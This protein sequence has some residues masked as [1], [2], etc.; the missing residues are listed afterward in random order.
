MIYKHFKIKIDSS[1]WPNGNVP[2]NL[3]KL[4][5][6]DYKI[7]ILEALYLIGKLTRPSVLK[8]FSLSDFWAWL[9]YFPAFDPHCSEAR[10]RK[11]WDSL[12]S[13]QKTIASD[14]L[15]MGFSCLF[16]KENLDINHFANT[17]HVLANLSKGL[18][19]PSPLIK[20]KGPKKTPDFIGFHF[21]N[22]LSI[23][24][25]KGTQNT[26]NALETSMMD[27]IEQKQNLQRKGA[28]FQHRLVAGTFI[29]QNSNSQNPTIKVIDPEWKIEGE[30][31]KYS[32]YDIEN[33]IIQ[34]SFAN[35]LSQIGF[36]N[37]SKIFSKTFEEEDI[38][39]SYEKDI[40]DID[41][42]G[43]KR[44]NEMWRKNIEVVWDEPMEYKGNSFGGIKY[45][46]EV[47]RTTIEEI[48]NSK[49]GSYFIKNFEEKFRSVKWN[50]KENIDNS[51]KFETESPLG[52]NYKLELI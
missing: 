45:S 9:R 38:D 23:I 2:S 5:N 3:L 22:D 52:I 50:K 32:K 13:H 31:L 37:L 18:Y 20:K 27:G 49:K 33:T 4:N 21:N 36:T 1:S 42:K 11:E 29:P 19:Q 12:D 26:L 6:I 51:H 16:L 8:G 24:E 44:E 41:R 30:F 43:F 34:L 25:C 28:V 7:N 17:T 47:P 40:K 48:K 15:G 35:D 14:D 39:S 46:I 10:F